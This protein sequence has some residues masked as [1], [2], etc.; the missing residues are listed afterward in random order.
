MN[1]QVLGQV[2][3]A[4]AEKRRANEAEEERITENQEASESQGAPPVDAP[5]N[6]VAP[7]EGSAVP[8]E[9]P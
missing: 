8:F 6:D 4:L 9:D 7:A 1:N 5:S 2:M 3:N